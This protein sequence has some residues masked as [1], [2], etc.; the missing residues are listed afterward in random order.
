MTKCCNFFLCYK[1]FATCWTLLTFCKT[2]C[3]TCRS[4]CCKNFFSVSCKFASNLFSKFTVA[5]AWIVCFV[6]CYLTCRIN[7]FNK[8]YTCMKCY[9]DWVEVVVAVY[10]SYCENCVL[11]S[12]ICV[13]FAC[14]FFTIIKLIRCVS[15]ITVDNNLR[16]CLQEKVEGT[17]LNLR[18]VSAVITDLDTGEINERILIVTFRTEVDC[19]IGSDCSINIFCKRDALEVCLRIC[20]C[21]I[22]NDNNLWFFSYCEYESTCHIVF[23]A[24][25]VNGEY[26][27][28]CAMTCKSNCC[29]CRNYKLDGGI[30]CELVRITV[31]SEC[32]RV[33]ELTACKSC[34]KSVCSCEIECVCLSECRK[35]CATSCTCTVFICMTK[36]CYF[37]TCLCVATSTCVCCVTCCCT[38]RSSYYCFVVVF[39][40]LIVNL[41][42]TYI[43]CVWTL[44]FKN[45]IFV[46]IQLNSSCKECFINCISILRTNCILKV[47][48]LCC[49]SYL[50]NNDLKCS[51]VVNN[52]QCVEF[53]KLHIIFS[54]CINSICRCTLV[55]NY[56]KRITWPCPV[57]SFAVFTISYYTVILSISTN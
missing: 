14:D 18:I 56:V 44:V 3:C 55:D 33:A 28:T 49:I 30:C 7:C 19:C 20:S 25:Y 40:K 8:C 24:V 32:T 29:I 22:R 5:F 35:N 37:I 47:S 34:A 53:L 50:N 27:I 41:Y 12:E 11:K 17:I 36:S 39:M 21:F 13:I 43:Y 51:S 1:N 52:C 48:K 15:G 6:T 46:S 54:C 10:R 9:F 42:I 2:C 57:K 16:A 31:V 4:Y 38:C 26:T 45:E 23:N